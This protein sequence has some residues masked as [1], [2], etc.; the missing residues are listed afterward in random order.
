MLKKL[1]VIAVSIAAL[2]FL[3]SS[4]SDGVSEDDE[5]E[6]ADAENKD[7]S[8][9]V[10]IN[11]ELALT[12]DA[13]EEYLD[14][15]IFL[16]ESTTYH[17]KSRGVLKDG[18]QTKQ[19]WAPKS[20]TLMLDA[21]TSNC[22]IV[23][24]ESREELDLAEALKRKK[25]SIMV[26]TFGLNGVIGNISRGED[27]FKSNY[28]RLI[29]TIRENSAKT[30]IIIQSC[31]PVAKNMDT[32]D[33][34]VDSATLNLYIDRLNLWASELAIDE[35]IGFINSAGILKDANGYL[36][37]EFQYGDGYHLT[38]GAYKEILY[39]IRTHKYQ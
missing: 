8:V 24:P 36:R 34:S 7:F 31:F 17:M 1:I 19:I 23:Y 37:D 4:C 32:E 11:A 2:Y 30:N 18:A 13:G 22:R 33:F 38:E 15:I 28:K 21:T 6:A 26:L 5:E 29:D 20:G 16:G 12:E 27:H 3:L 9:C 25:P 10:G 14:S 39:Y 35:N